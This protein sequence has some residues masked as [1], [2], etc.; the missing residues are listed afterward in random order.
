MCQ[1]KIPDVVIRPA[2]TP[3]LTPFRAFI[4]SPINFIIDIY[5]ITGCV[6]LGNM[7]TDY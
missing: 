1:I 7:F 3:D 4:I 6:S 2:V 5:A